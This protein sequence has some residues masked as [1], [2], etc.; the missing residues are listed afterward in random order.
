MENLMRTYQVEKVIPKT[1][2]LTIDTLPFQAGEIVQV[3][4]LA[5]DAGIDSTDLLPLTGS[6]LVYNDPTEP[7]AEHDWEIL[8][9]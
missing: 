3:I 2:I 9:P 1:G 7:V 8:Q 6:V 4:I 5:R